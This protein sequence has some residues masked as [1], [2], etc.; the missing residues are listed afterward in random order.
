MPGIFE[1]QCE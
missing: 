1:L